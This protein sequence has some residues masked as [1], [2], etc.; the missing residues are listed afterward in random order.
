V[1]KHS[2]RLSLLIL[3]TTTMR[4]YSQMRLDDWEKK[5][6]TYTSLKEA[7]KQPPESVV[8]ISLF[9]RYAVSWDEV[10][11][12]KKIR[13]LELIDMFGD[14]FP[15]CIC[16]L[17]ELQYLSVR[18]NKLGVLPT[19]ITA[20]TKL[21]FLDLY[22]NENLT[23]L[24][25]GFEKLSNLQSVNIGGNPGLN[26]GKTFVSL[27]K[28]PRLK[29]LNLTFDKIQSL[30]VEIGL[31]TQIEELTIDNN[32]LTDLPPQMAAMKNLKRLSLINN[33]FSSIPKIVSA[34]PAI[35]QVDLTNTL[36]EDL[37]KSLAGSYGHNKIRESEAK[38]L[39]KNKPGLNLTF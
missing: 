21:E 17:G 31:L 26:L 28:L 24:P 7:A 29:T 14:K 18:N 30:P 19:E 39:K 35:K 33:K 38:T 2:L 36:E 9:T 16:G 22:W 3:M 12:Y 1:K 6:P 34:L 8:K 15:M 23:Y 25:E 4:S 27:A 10:C 32:L 13:G 37:D 5:F 20:L 11:K